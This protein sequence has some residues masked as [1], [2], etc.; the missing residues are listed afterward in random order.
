MKILL[1][2]G[3]GYIGGHI[4][5]ELQKKDKKNINYILNLR[6]E[7]GMSVL[8]GLNILEKSKNI[9]I[10]KKFDKKRKGDSSKLI[11]NSKLANKVLEW[12]AKISKEDILNSAYSWHYKIL[13]NYGK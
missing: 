11:S 7:E 1:T 3:A 8:E 2:G 9:K 4:C 12:K 13:K 5:K 10:K 6:S